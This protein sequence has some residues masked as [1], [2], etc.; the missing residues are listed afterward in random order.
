MR[1]SG[2]SHTFHPTSHPSFGVNSGAESGAFNEEEY[3][4]EEEEELEDELAKLEEY[5]EEGELTPNIF[6]ISNIA[7]VNFAD[8]DFPN[9]SFTFGQPP[10]FT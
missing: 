9:P 3:F 7:K 6:G 4:D 8:V 2:P 10:F 5:Y 1:N